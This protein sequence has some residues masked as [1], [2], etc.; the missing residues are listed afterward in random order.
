MNCF[1]WS[2][3]NMNIFCI[4]NIFETDQHWMIRFFVDQVMFSLIITRSSWP[5]TRDIPKYNHAITWIGHWIIQIVKAQIIVY[6]TNHE[7]IIVNIHRTKEQCAPH[8]RLLKASYTG[9][10]CYS[11]S[12]TTAIFGCFKDTISSTP[13]PR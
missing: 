13:S 8:F 10:W 3:Q 2:K 4:A 7:V 12:N 1:K 9:S 5:Y 6:S 11:M